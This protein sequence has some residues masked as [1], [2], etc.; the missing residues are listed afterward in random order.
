MP[1]QRVGK[2]GLRAEALL[3][4]T[5]GDVCKQPILAAEQMGDAAGIET[6]A[7]GVLLKCNTRRPTLCCFAEAAEQCTVRFRRMPLDPQVGN[8]RARFRQRQ[9]GPQARASGA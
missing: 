6:Q 8:A 1:P 3:L 5:V 9:P 7:A 2:A 4:Q